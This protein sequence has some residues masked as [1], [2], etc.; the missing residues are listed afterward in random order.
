MGLAL[1]SLGGVGRD[2]FALHGSGL[3]VRAELLAR[4]MGGEDF[5]DIAPGT[6]WGE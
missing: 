1:V 5:R 3:V 4:A 2:C 6:I